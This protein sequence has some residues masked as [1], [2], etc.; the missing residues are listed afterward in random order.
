LKDNIDTLS[1]T[2]GI[3]LTNP[4]REQAAGEFSADIVAEDDSGDVV[5]IENQL[6]KSNH[7]HLGKIVTYVSNLDAKT[8]VWIVSDARPEHINAVSW[9]NE[10]NLA[11]FYLLK[12]EAIQ[13]NDSE[14][15]PLLTLIVGPSEEAREVGNAKKE[16]SERDQLRRKFWTALMEL[17]GGM[18]QLHANITPQSYSWLGAS[19][20][21]TGLLYTYTAKQHETGVELYIDRGKDSGEESKRIFDSLAQSK[22]EIE[23]Q[24]GGPLEWQRLDGARACRIKKSL[25]VGGYRDDEGKWPEIQEAMVKAMIALDGAFRELVA[26]LK[27]KLNL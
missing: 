13:I 23:R 17:A 11:S 9:L 27:N 18:T 7:D 5:V 4:E 10:A 8:A 16:L 22:T 2:L 3:S 1:E 12:V 14:P 24:F 21:I 20:G 26:N 25:N 6:E 19:A 15:A